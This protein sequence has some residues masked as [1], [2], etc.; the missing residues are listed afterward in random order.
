MNFANCFISNRLPHLLPTLPSSPTRP[1]TSA[2]KLYYT[3]TSS[4]AA[5]CISATI[6][7]LKFDSEQVSIGTH[8]TASVACFLLD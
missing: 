2:L 5:F 7:G 8:K 4:S 1:V 3:P 6:A